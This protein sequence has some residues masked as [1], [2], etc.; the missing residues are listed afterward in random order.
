MSLGRIEPELATLRR[1]AQQLAKQRVEPVTSVHW[2]AAISLH[3][4]VGRDLL[5]ER[6]IDSA[7]ILAAIS[8]RDEDTHLI[9]S[10]TESARHTAISMD[11]SHTG[12][13]H[14]LI[15]FL[16]ETSSCARR[17][18]TALKVDPLKLRTSALQL[19]MGLR[20]RPTSRA[21]E[22]TSRAAESA[23]PSAAFKG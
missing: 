12:G 17:T 4:G 18:L 2:L 15:S 16:G 10:A 11:A 20:Q 7:R 6:R 23:P 5:A 21:V 1:L 3:P 13:L 9:R 14:L 8:G 19:G 22:P